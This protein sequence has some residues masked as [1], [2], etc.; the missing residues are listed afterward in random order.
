MVKQLAFDISA[1][2]GRPPLLWFQNMKAAGY[3]L[4]WIQL[5]EQ[6]GRDG[7]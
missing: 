4:C 2:Q 7:E 3:D 5:K 1:W 6:G